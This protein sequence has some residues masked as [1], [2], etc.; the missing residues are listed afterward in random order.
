MISNLSAKLLLFVL[1]LFSIPLN[2]QTRIGSLQHHMDSMIGQLPGAGGN[3]WIQPSPQDLSNWDQMFTQ[4][5]RN[6]VDTARILADTLNYEIALFY[7]TLQ[8]EKALYYL[9]R[10]KNPKQNY[11]GIYAINPLARRSRLVLQAPHPRFDFRTGQQ[12]TFCFTRLSARALFI[13]GTHRCNM[14]DSVTCSGKTTA[15]GVSA[16]YKVSDMAH[17]D[18]SIFQLSTEILER[19]LD[20]AVFI[21][22]HGF[23]KLNSD[24]YLIMSNG[25]RFI[26][27]VD[28]VSLIRDELVL[29]D[30]ILTFKIAH[31]D[32]L[33]DRLNGTTNVQGRTINGSGNPCNTSPNGTTGRF[34][35]IEQERYRLREDSTGWFKMFSAFQ[36]VFTSD[37]THQTKF[38]LGIDTSWNSGFNWHP[39]GVPVDTN[40]AILLSTPPGGQHARL[41]ADA[42]CLNLYEERDAELRTR[43]FNLRVHGNYFHKGSIWIETGGSLQIEP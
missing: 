28:Y 42:E 35:H 17:Q 33:W 32:T 30:T 14:N 27:N 37:T 34:L 31:V 22:H 21:Q 19:E 29:I 18:T 6:N 40:H 8:Q 15:C 25:T 16:S 26:P 36:N 9:L 24:P 11:W 10:E 13:S 43:H 23:T 4:L 38:W 2:G 20:Q 1:A 5:L 12:A 3:N 7:D 39:G 41:N